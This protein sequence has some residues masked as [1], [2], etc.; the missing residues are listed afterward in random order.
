MP[1]KLILIL[2]ICV[3]PFRSFAAED[4]QKLAAEFF[5]WRAITQ[6]ATSDD[7]NRVERPDGW[8]RIFVSININ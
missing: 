1:T 4:L 8:T 3:L 2:G 6:P 5:A 7:I